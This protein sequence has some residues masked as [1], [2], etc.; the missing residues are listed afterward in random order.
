MRWL[1]VFLI[2][3]RIACTPKAPRVDEQWRAIV[4]AH[5]VVEG[6]W[7]AVVRLLSINR[8]AG[9]DAPEVVEFVQSSWPKP[10]AE[11]PKAVISAAQSLR[12]TISEVSTTGTIA[13]VAAAKDLNDLVNV[14]QIL[15]LTAKS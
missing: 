10:Q 7:E 13:N 11:A 8:R 12:S 15:L 6:E 2:A 5:P 3:C 1:L 4:A 14:G 9:L